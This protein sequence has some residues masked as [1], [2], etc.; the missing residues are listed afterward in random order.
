MKNENIRYY[1]YKLDEEKCDKL[2]E[3]EYFR[4]SL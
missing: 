2:K 1:E 3:K 4:N